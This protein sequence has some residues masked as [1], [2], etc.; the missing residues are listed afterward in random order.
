MSISIRCLSSTLVPKCPRSIRPQKNYCSAKLHTGIA[1]SLPP[2][3]TFMLFGT[4][5]SLVRQEGAAAK[6]GRGHHRCPPSWRGAPPEKAMP[7][8][9]K[10]EPTSPAAP[11]LVPA[12]AALALLHAPQLTRRRLQRAAEFAPR[13]RPLGQ[14]AVYGQQ[15][16]SPSM[17]DNFRFSVVIR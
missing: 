15:G 17:R 13:P 7:S 4:R 16:I 10:V 2:F 11:A 9:P 12:D 3:S 8:A 1:R 14:T 6:C 5:R